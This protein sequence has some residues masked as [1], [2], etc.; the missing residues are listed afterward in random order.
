MHFTP[1]KKVSNNRLPK[2]NSLIG[3]HLFPWIHPKQMNSPSSRYLWQ[4]FCLQRGGKF[5]PHS[6]NFLASHL[7]TLEIA[8]F[9]KQDEFKEPKLQMIMFT[10]SKIT[11]R[12]ALTTSSKQIPVH[13]VNSSYF[14]RKS[15]LIPAT[16][17]LPVLISWGTG[18][19]AAHHLAFTANLAQNRLDQQGSHRDW[20][21]VLGEIVPDRAQSWCK[22][23]HQC[24][25]S[26]FFCA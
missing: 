18:C 24:S 9:S 15:L 17:E 12:A 14:V 7:P 20:I 13:R 22:H 8:L 23:E 25:I 10:S 5:C 16:P 2:K 3:I 19:S 4:L 11:S 1:E 6:S 21:A 26:Y